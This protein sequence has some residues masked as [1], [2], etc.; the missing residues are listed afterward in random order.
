MISSFDLKILISKIQ[1]IRNI[2]TLKIIIPRIEKGMN[3]IIYTI[4]T[5]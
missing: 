1:C 2:G 5:L 4:K 3:L